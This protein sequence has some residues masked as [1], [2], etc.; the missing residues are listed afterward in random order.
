MIY[1][2]VTL[3]G[4]IIIVFCLVCVKIWESRQID[5]AEEQIEIM[6]RRDRAIA[7]KDYEL[8]SSNTG[9]SEFQINTIYHSLKKSGAWNLRAVK[10]KD[11][12]IYFKKNDGMKGYFEIKEGKVGVVS[13][14]HIIVMHNG[15]LL[16]SPY[17]DKGSYNM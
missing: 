9:L 11:R 8:L 17:E 6:E 12:R 10:M 3:T 13:L 4:C 16:M 1:E 14:N 5:I 15:D 7:Q 2:L